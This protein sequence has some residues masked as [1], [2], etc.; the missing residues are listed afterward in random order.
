MNRNPISKREC[1]LICGAF[2]SANFYVM[3]SVIRS[4]GDVHIHAIS[5]NN[6]SNISLPH[7]DD[8][9]Y[10]H[11]YNWRLS[12]LSS[13]KNCLP[14]LLFKGV[15]YLFC[16]ITGL[17]DNYFTSSYE[18]KIYRKSKS[19]LKEY[20][21]DD[22]FSVCLRFYTHRI[23]LKLYLE[24][25]F[26][27]YQFWVDPFSNRKE[28]KTSLW[29][30]GASRLEE[31]F[32][33]DASVIYALPEV[34]VG[35]EIIPRYKQKLVTFEIPY[36]VNQEVERKTKDIIFAG[37]F[38]KNVRD[39][40]PVLDLLMSVLNDIDSAV[41]FH[42]YIRNKELYS[43]Y[44]VKSEGRLCFH[45][46]IGHEELSRR[47]SASYMLLNIGNAGSIQMPSKTVEYVSFRKPL[48][49][50]YKD[51]N[52]ASLRYLKNY[53]DICRIC[54]DDELEE[55]RKKLIAFLTASHSPISYETLMQYKEFRESTPEYIRSQLEQ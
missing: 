45:D 31:C 27:W 51:R 32:L 37:A 54:V 28:R 17:Y 5:A 55:N 13:I 25:K 9:T 8:V 24:C 42:F 47:L 34:F 53:P 30:K 20:N 18:R 52:D 46:Y 49:F 44:N 35:S 7:Y 2:T 23:A 33:K 50:F 19:I 38:I 10:Y 36:L 3:L 4:L 48:L 6:E 16:K 15:D 40:Y 39:P 12:F 14:G 43:E 29:Y 11:V 41:S 22:V 1:L 21:I 26:R